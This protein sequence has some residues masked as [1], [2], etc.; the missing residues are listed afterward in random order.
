MLDN[1]RES[2][3][4]QGHRSTKAIVDILCDTNVL[5]Y[6][7][8]GRHCANDFLHLMGIYSGATRTFHLWFRWDL[9]KWKREIA[10]YMA[11]WRSTKFLRLTASICNT[12]NPFAFNYTSCVNY[13][14]MY[15]KVF[16]HCVVRVPRELYNMMVRQGLLDQNHIIGKC[17][18]SFLALHIE[19]LQVNPIWR[20]MI[21]FVHLATRLSLYT[22]MGTP[23]IPIPS[24]VHGL[25]KAGSLVPRWV[26]YLHLFGP[27]LL[28][29][30]A[31]SWRRE[32]CWICYY[33][34]HC[35]I[36]ENSSWTRPI[37]RME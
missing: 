25:L 34:W 19:C 35:R 6:S 13:F 17:T 18:C 7:G 11:T 36:S 5:A 12:K 27:G 21:C 24:S 20:L 26:C 23:W 14:G 9:R 10:S 2:V 16:R 37:L 32:I 1:W 30:L 15:L 8:F 31:Q 28:G 4:V 29:Y 22:T 3:C 33:S